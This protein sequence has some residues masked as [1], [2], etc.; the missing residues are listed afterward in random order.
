MVKNKK[1]R[2]T[3]KSMKK[4]I[5]AVVMLAVMGL[6]NGCIAQAEEVEK[7]VEKTEIIEKV[8]DIPAKETIDIQVIKNQMLRVEKDIQAIEAEE[9]LPEIIKKAGLLPRPKID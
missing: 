3:G 7:A 2:E 5:Y 8:I 9:M 1:E 6:F 4:C